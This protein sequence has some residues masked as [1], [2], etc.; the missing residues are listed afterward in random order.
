[1]KIYGL[2]GYPLGH[3][4]SRGYFTEKFSRESITDSTY[5]NFPL[6]AVNLL[7]PLIESTPSL[8]GLNITIPYKEQVIHLLDELSDAATAIGAVNTI[9]ITRKDNEIKMK[10]FNTDV[11]GFQRSLEFFD[12]EIPSKTL[13]LGTGG[14]AKAVKW[15]LEKYDTNVYFATRNPKEGN[16]L[17]Y[18]EIS[19]SGLDEFKL[20]INTTPLGMYPSIDT[21][22]E[23]PYDTLHSGHTLFDLVYNP[24][25]TAFMKEGGKRKCKIING[26][27]ML[28][29][30]ADE[31]WRIWN[32]KEIGKEKGLT[33]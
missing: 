23:L 15:V 22:P 33:A 5:K 13:V 17:N 30:Q 1:M 12:V 19:E 24:L 29:Q 10:G 3:S 16:Q 25:E 8:I 11:N 9:K 20:I 26:L 28:E 27:H 18:S 7:L 31:S 2:I 4:F 32:E 21:L 6:K 14:A